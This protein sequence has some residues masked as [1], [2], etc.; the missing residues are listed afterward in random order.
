MKYSLADYILSV[1]FDDAAL[2]QMFGDISIGGEGDAV[3]SIE[4]SRTQNMWETETFS[5]GAWVHN[6]NLSKAG[7]AVLN[8]SQLSNKVERLKMMFNIYY[9][10]DYG[11]CTLTLVDGYGNKVCTCTKT[12]KVRIKARKSVLSEQIF[13][14]KG[15]M[16]EWKFTRT[17]RIVLK[18]VRQI[19][20]QE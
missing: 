10:G 20:C 15:E 7:T 8:I 6:K 16:T 2:N 17:N 19:W 4:I 5:T 13:K 12:Q 11:G 18:S 3:G 9:T 14:K 1:K